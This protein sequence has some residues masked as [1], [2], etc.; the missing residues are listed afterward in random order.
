MGLKE[1]PLRL[2]A[3][4]VELVQVAQVLG[5]EVGVD[6]GGAHA[7]VAEHLLHRAEVRA[8]L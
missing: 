7:R 8:G 4:A 5:V 6:L 3:G 1:P 2:G